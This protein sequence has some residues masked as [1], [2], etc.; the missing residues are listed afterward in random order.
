MACKPQAWDN[1]YC[2]LLCLQL[3]QDGAQHLRKTGTNWTVLMLSFKISVPQINQETLLPC[4][5]NYHHTEQVFPQ[6]CFKNAGL[7][8]K[9]QVPYGIERWLWVW[10][11]ATSVHAS[12]FCSCCSSLFPILYLTCL[13]LILQDFTLPR[14]SPNRLKASLLMSCITLFD[15]QLLKDKATSYSSFS[16]VL[17]QCLQCTTQLINCWWIKNWFSFTMKIFILGWHT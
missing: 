1:M 12:V 7:Q 3:S 11:H 8:V 15:Y 2:S 14:P 6:I 13:Y 16:Q 4:K 5:N 17:A 9:T 10:S